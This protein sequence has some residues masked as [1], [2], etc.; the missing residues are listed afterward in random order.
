MDHHQL[1]NR[2]IA[3]MTA[4]DPEAM[5]DLL[6]DDY[7][8]IYP[9]SGEILRG[10]D[11]WKGAY[12]HNPDLPHGESIHTTGADKPETQVIRPV[13]GIGMPLI[14]LS[15]SDNRFTN[16]SI[17]EYSNGE[18]RFTVILGEIKDG[19]IASTTLY[20]CLPFEP[21]EWRA[22]YAEQIPPHEYFN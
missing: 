21:A 11:A 9:Q 8:E 4:G 18:K 12:L 3:G 20:S 14:Q 13:G 15:E 2:F 5:V 6:H 22:P 19:K 17:L 10:L 1:V 16:E 7:T